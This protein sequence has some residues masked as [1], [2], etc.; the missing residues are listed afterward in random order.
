MNDLVM[1]KNT[2][3]IL[4]EELLLRKE[5]LKREAANI[6]RNYIAE[7]GELLRQAFERKIECIRRK[8]KIAYCQMCVN[9]GKPIDG[10][11]LSEYLS[12]EMQEYEE[13]LKAMISDIQD[14]KNSKVVSAEDLR[15]IRRIY[16]RLARRIHPDMRPDLAGDETLTEYWNRIAA[17]YRGNRLAELEELEVLV[18]KRLTEMKA[19]KGIVTIDNIDERISRLKKEVD[20]IITTEPFVFRFILEDEKK[21][22][23]RKN[24]LC[25]EIRE[26]ETYAAELDAV[27]KTYSIRE[28][29]A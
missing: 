10:S 23:V 16:Y 12:S 2:S 19:G 28:M 9:Q 25:G 21:R 7:F 1:V 14:A 24:E 4:Y 26:Y 13:Q 3:Y 15:R 5:N 18:E 11:G 8:K 22:E 20:R 6:E 17:A 29:Y 27:L